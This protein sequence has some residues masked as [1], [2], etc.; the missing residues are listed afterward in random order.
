MPPFEAG[1]L[2]FSAIAYPNEPSNR[3]EYR[4]ALCWHALAAN[5]ADPD[6][7]WKPQVIKPGYAFQDRD[8]MA[9][10]FDRGNDRLRKQ[11]L[12][13]HYFAM[14][15]L[16]E[17]ITGR[18]VLG[19]GSKLGRNRLAEVAGKDPRAPYADVGNLKGL[20]FKP[21]RPVIHAAAAIQGMILD[22]ENT[23]QA[24]RLRP[25]G[26]GAVFESM[27]YDAETI[28]ELITLAEKWRLTLTGHAS[29][30]LPEAETIQFALAWPAVY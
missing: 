29:F 8:A 14:P 17:L 30:K 12:A 6:W 23:G 15:L 10:A 28:I 19:N 24:H 1:S 2:I 13:A 4:I 7:A 18:N 26:G 20:L 11:L 5:A 25:G 3:E 21:S 27:V 16:T 22:W 9:G